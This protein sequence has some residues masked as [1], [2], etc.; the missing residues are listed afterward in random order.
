MSDTEETTEDPFPAKVEL[1]VHLDGAVRTQT[2]LDIAK[3]REIDLPEKTIEE[4]DQ[5][6]KIT[7]EE[8]LD[9]MLDAFDYFLPIIRGDKEALEQIISDFCEDC[10]KQNIYYAEVRFAPHILVD[11]NSE[12]ERCRQVRDIVRIATDALKEGCKKYSIKLRLILCCMR[13]QPEN[14]YEVL[15]LCDEFR[16][17]YVVGIDIAGAEFLTDAESPL[18]TVFQEAHDIGIHRT[19]H[20]GEVGAAENVIEA[21]NE[22]HAERIGHGYHVIE[23]EKLYARV[24]ED[25]IHLE[26]CPSSSFR[27][28]AFQGDVK[29][30]PMK[31]FAD[32]GINFSLNT[33]D[34]CVFATNLNNE[35]ALAEEAGLSKEQIIK[36]FFNAAQS[37]FLPDDERKELVKHL[38]SVY[39]N[40]SLWAVSS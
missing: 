2:L 37:C 21:L 28:K 17:D 7:K 29:S 38:H 32:D 39:G 6:V 16:N 14:A 31:K 12:T 26:I 24:K 25:R 10:A 9:K 5:K 36:S 20:A 11:P 27:T 19:A 4:L 13:N 15:L 1:H 40:D 30:H 34:P 8:G 35:Y 33:D 3:R 23:D 22:M 18:K